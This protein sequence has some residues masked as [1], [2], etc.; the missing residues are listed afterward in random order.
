METDA[1]RAANQ[2]IIPLRR[3]QK[4][5]QRILFS[6]RLVAFPSVGDMKLCI[7]LAV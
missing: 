2:K 1:L 7:N 3:D 6:I 5:N 4:N